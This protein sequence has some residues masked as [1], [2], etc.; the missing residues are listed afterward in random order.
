MGVST[1]ARP[2]DALL[3]GV[4]ILEPLLLTNGFQFRFG[5]A[6]SGSGGDFAW[7]EFVR[8]DRRLELHFR[9]SLGLVRYH[10]GQQSSS[11]ESYMR[12]LGIWDQCR[13]PGFADDP[14]NAFNELT[15]DLDYADDFL[16]GPG[17]ILRRAAAKETVSTADREADAMAGYIG[18]KRKVN[19]L[20]TCLREKRYGEV[21]RLARN[22]KYPSLMSEADR[23]MV[24]IS[25][26][27]SGI[28]GFFARF[29]HR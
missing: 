4:R 28:R 1:L 15:H 21:V 19:Q 6:G 29:R 22:L 10:V 27:K 16:V 11:H 18:D 17:T 24:E 26:K 8:D 12:E 20:R 5:G 14:M 2:K 3:D 23:K 13:Y 25:R 7:G 9:R